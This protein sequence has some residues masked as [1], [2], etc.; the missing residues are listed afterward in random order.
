MLQNKKVKQGLAEHKKELQRGTL[1]KTIRI[2]A[3]I[4]TK[5]AKQ[6][7]A[8]TARKSKFVKSS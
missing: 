5:T 2:Q 7:L 6:G 1:R 8:K 4:G 3:E